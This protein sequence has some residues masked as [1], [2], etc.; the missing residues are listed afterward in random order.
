MTVSMICFMSM[1]MTNTV[2][3]WFLRL[4]LETCNKEMSR[5]FNRI[6]LRKAKTPWSFDLSECKKV[7]NRTD[8]LTFF[9]TL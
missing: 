9:N 8:K 1:T 7:K 4:I 2:L 5:S 3:Q 6:A